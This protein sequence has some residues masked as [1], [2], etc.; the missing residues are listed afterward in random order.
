MCRSGEE[1]QECFEA[2]KRIGEQQFA[3]AGVFLE[4]YI[5]HGRHIEV[6]IFG[7]GRGG[8]VV[9][10]DRDCSIQR[11]NQ[12]IIEEAP[13]PLLPDAT[14]AAM[15]LCARK[16]GEIVS[17]RSAGTVEFIYDF[18]SDK[19]YFLEVNTRI[20]VEHT[21]TEMVTGLDIVESMIRLA[22]DADFDISFM[23]V[24]TRGVAIEV[25]IN[26]EDPIHS[27]KPSPG[28][29]TEV[30]FP[31]MENIRIDSG[32]EDGSEVSV[33]YDSMIAKIIVKSESRSEA[34]QMILN[35]LKNTSI[36]GI[37]TN[38][39]FLTS[40]ISSFAFNEP[41][42]STK[43]LSTFDYLPCV[44]E[45][46]EPGGYTTIQDYPGRVKKWAVG[47]PPSGPMDD[48][49]FRL[50]NRIVGNASDCAGLECTLTGPKLLF[51]MDALVAVAG[52]SVDCH[53]D[54]TRVP[55]FSPILVKVGQVFTIGKVTSGVRCYLAVKGGIRSPSYL[56]SRSTFVLGKFGGVHGDGSTVKSG[57]YLPLSKQDDLISAAPLISESLLSLFHFSPRTHIGVLYGPHGAPD[58]FTENSINEFFST[59]Y[60]VHYNSSR[61]GVRL[62]GPKPIWAR[63]D[64]GEA[65]LH[66]SNIH[67]CEYAIGDVA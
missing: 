39:D 57:D 36:L 1:L 8:V 65:G 29:L 52:A 53:V 34:I 17:Y 58:F 54:G 49:S 41:R 4:Q 13:A 63:S 44:I 48:L 38:I 2:V 16:L 55:M 10:G 60:E 51:H 5:E 67:D 59:D 6:Q 28:K 11:R 31:S 64:G 22:F 18:V 45:V 30:I 23:N 27:F 26:A 56:G 46:L 62:I 14:R 24:M 43:F 7:D 33:F 66:P 3:N 19:F 35:A 50:A 32:V 47:V 15:H 25:R 21:V 20:Q 37:H 61:L 9:L 42:L 12:K 40:I